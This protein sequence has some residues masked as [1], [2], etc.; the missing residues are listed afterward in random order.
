MADGRSQIMLDPNHQVDRHRMVAAVA[1]QFGRD[2]FGS[3]NYQIILSVLRPHIE[4]ASGEQFCTLE[5][6]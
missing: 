1:G 2:R 6:L 4:V 3:P 5:C